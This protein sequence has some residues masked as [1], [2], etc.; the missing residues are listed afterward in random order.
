MA[1]R[2]EREK[3][4]RVEQHRC[5]LSVTPQV[6]PPGPQ[7]PPLRHLPVPTPLRPGWAH[8]CEHLLECHSSPSTSATSRGGKGRE[9]RVWGPCAPGAPLAMLPPLRHPSPSPLVSPSDEGPPQVFPM[10]PCHS[11]GLWGW[12]SLMGKGRPQVGTVPHKPSLEVWCPRQTILPTPQP[13]PGVL[14]SAPGVAVVA[15]AGAGA[16]PPTWVTSWAGRDL[17]A[18]G[19][20]GQGTPLGTSLPWGPMGG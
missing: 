3:Q 7:V 8:S 10:V 17:W 4:N 11:L 19:Q 12:A 18:G 16:V 15:T 5:H 9:V 14:T 13:W 6:P 1:S 2:P 20:E